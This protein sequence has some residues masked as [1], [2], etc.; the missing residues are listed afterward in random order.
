MAARW[1]ADSPA[2]LDRTVTSLIL[3]GDSA[4]GTLAIVA[5][6]DLRDRAIVRMQIANRMI[7]EAKRRLRKP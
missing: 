3:C 5:A 2:A 7:D 4:G 6:M 1:V